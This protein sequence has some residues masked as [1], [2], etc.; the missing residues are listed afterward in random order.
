MLRAIG[1][2]TASS[3]FLVRLADARLQAGD[4]DAGLAAVKD[5]LALVQTSLD[6]YNVA[7]LHRMNGLLRQAM[8]DAD[9]AA[10]SLR[11]AIAVARRQ[12]ALWFELQAATDL[13]RQLGESGRREEGQR[14]LADVLGRTD[15]GADTNPVIRARMLL[16]ELG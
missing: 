2:R 14:L 1:F 15:E 11:E 7:Q 5:G 12:G 6:R 4:H 8:G 10:A 13:A 16:A 9:G 3:T